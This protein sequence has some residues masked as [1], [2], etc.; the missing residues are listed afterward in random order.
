VRLV[1]HHARV[2]A[3]RQL[4]DLRQRRGVAVHGEDAVGDDQGAAAGGLLEAP[5]EVVDVAVVVDEG[6]RARQPAAVDDRGVVERVGEDHVA[7]LRERGHHAGVGEEARAE[8]QARLGAL[9]VGELLL[10]AT[11]D[12]HVARH[13][14]R[15]T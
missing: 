4:D 14:P 9:E 12:R 15:R 6:L 1:D 10:Q 5:L 11:V 13:Q 3:L 7:L 8:Q 2:V